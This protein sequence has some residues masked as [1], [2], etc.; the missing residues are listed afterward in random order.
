MEQEILETG[1]FDSVHVPVR[2][3]IVFREIPMCSLLWVDSRLLLEYARVS[4]LDR[5]ALT[6]KEDDLE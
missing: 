4:S 5:D 3:F 2:S 1:R 6:Y